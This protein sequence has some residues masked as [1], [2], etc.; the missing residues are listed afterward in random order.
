LRLLVRLA[1]RLRARMKL[2]RVVQ[3]LRRTRR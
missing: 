1:R 3:P 2:R